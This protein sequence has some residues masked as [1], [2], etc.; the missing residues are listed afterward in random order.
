MLWPGWVTLNRLITSRKLLKWL[1]KK[2][3]NCHELVVKRVWSTI[4]YFNIYFLNSHCFLSHHWVRANWT[5]KLAPP[6]LQSTSSPFY[7]ASS[8][9][10]FICSFDWNSNV[11]NEFR[12]DSSNWSNQ[13]ATCCGLA[14]TKT[15][16]IL[17]LNWYG[18]KQRG[19]VELLPST[20]Y[21]L[22]VIKI[23]SY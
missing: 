16:W 6:N 10:W 3:K 7:L 18:L 13:N 8:A 15:I 19:K 14:C 21:I 22:F 12:L 9:L 23:T 4:Y 17:W 20:F 11:E 1:Q 5:I 2:G